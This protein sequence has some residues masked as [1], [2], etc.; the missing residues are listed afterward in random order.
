M[1]VD[2]STILEKG[3]FSI[4]GYRYNVEYIDFKIKVVYWYD[5]I[6]HRNKDVKD[7]MGIFYNRK[8]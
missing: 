3:F 4:D 2:G 6:L 7:F 1:F 5:G 8:L